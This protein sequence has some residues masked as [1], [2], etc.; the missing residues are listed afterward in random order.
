[1]TNP[2]D[3]TLIENT[4][5]LTMAAVQTFMLGYEKFLVDP[6]SATATT[7]GR[8]IAKLRKI[9]N[10]EAVQLIKFRKLNGST[11][12]SNRIGYYRRV[13]KNSCGLHAPSIPISVIQSIV[14]RAD[15]GEKISIDELNSI[16]DSY[17]CPVNR[18]RRPTS[19]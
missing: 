1:M 5:E 12:S 10:T 9:L 13:L 19:I 14:D 7:T 17:P 6:N 15:A 18:S 3:T 2:K 8:D 4:H 11:N 16:R